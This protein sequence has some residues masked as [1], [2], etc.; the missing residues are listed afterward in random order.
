MSERLFLEPGV[1]MGEW[2][3][4]LEDGRFQCDLCPRHCRLRPGQRG[5]CTVR[6]GRAQGIALTSYGRNSGMAVD[7]IE[8]KPLNHFLPGSRVLSFGT[9]GCN[10]G[11]RYCQNWHISK[12]KEMDRLGVEAGPE[13][14]LAR[15]RNS[16]CEG[17]AFTYNDPVIFAEYAMDTAILAHAAGL[18]T[19]AVTAGYITA[20]ARR[21]LFRHIDAANVDLKAFT[22]DF[23][24]RLC[25]GALDPVLET[26][27]WLKRE[28]EVW[29]E[30]TTLV[31]PG[32][33][34]GEDEI[35]RECEWILENLGPEVPL[36]FS[37]FHP[38]FRMLDVPPTPTSTLR[39]ARQLALQA[40][41]RFVYTG[42][43]FD[44]EGASTYCPDCGKLVIGR[45]GYRLTHWSLDEEGRCKG[46]GSKLP[47]NL[48]R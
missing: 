39:R 13:Q 30:I 21:E 40:G 46:C 2:W 29:F 41:L 12:V 27:R 32:H 42:N 8:K 9:A 36:H 35:E 31:I 7:P 18:K 19:V 25:Y 47:G 3:H 34:D 38:D 1:V 11:C 37:A 4:P 17:I 44:P 28:S 43:V 33:N 45:A 14:V 22:N 10:L 16:E 6:Q 15:A 24:R 26:L 20:Q 48:Q 23:Y 5:F